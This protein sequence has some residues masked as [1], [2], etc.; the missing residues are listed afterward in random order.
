M[1]LKLEDE[2]LKTSPKYSNKKVFFPKRYIYIY[3]YIY[4]FIYLFIYLIKL[5]KC[6]IFGRTRSILHSTTDIT[7]VIK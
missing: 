1:F 2:K 7:R 6:P 5:S 3:I 4:I